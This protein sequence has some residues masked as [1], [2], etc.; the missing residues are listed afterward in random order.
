M[1]HQFKRKEAPWLQSV[2]MTPQLIYEY[3]FPKHVSVSKVLEADMEKLE[4]SKQPLQVDS[5]LQ[6]LYLNLEGLQKNLIMTEGP[7]FF[8]SDSCL[9][10]ES[11]LR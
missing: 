1:P 3:Q 9:S 6:Q 2:E 4:L 11:L 10:S 8:E 7:S 5:Q